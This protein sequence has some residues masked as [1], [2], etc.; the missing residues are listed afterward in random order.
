MENEKK[1]KDMYKTKQYQV[2]TSKKSRK[3]DENNKTKKGKKKKK[4]KVLKRIILTFFIL[5]FLLIIAAVG[6]V[7]G[8][9][10]SDKWAITTAELIAN[11]NTEV[12][13]SENNLLAVLS[14]RGGDG[15]RKVVALDEMGKY[16]ANAYIAIEDKRFYEHSGVDLIRTAKATASYILHRGSSDVGGGSTLTQQLVKN[17]MKDDDNTG[18]AGMERKIREMSRAYQIEGMLT[19]QQ[20]IEK[21]L[22]VI[23][24]GGNDLHGVEY[25]AQYYF[26]KSAKDLDLAESAFLAGINNAPNMYDPYDTK[27]DHSELIKNRTKLVL[28]FMKEQ[29]RISDNPEEAEKLYN[30]AVAKVEKGL[31]FKKGKIELENISYFVAEAVKDVARDLA[32]ERDISLDEAQSMIRSGGYK[33]YTTQVPSIQNKVISEMAKE[34]YIEKRTITKKDENGKTVKETLR[35]NAGMTIIEHSTGKVVAMGGDLLQDVGGN[36]NHAMLINRQNGSSMKPLA[37]IAVGLEEKVITAATIYDDTRTKFKEMPTAPKNVGSYMG[38]I[39]TRKAIEVSSNIVNLKIMSNIGINK[40]VEYLNEF[41]LTT[42]KKGEEGLTLAIGGVEHGSST[43]QMAAA[44]AT[45]ANKGVYIE[46]TFYTKL[47]DSDGKIV[48]EPKQETRRVISEA[49]AFIVS[50]ILMDVVTGAQGT[51]GSCAIS[52]MDVAAKTGTTDNSTDRTLCGYTPYYA[53]ATWYGYGDSTVPIRKDT[54]KNIW[55]KVMK[56]VHKNLP[57]KRFEKPDS[58]VTAKVCRASGKLAT[59]SCKSTYSE[60]FAVGNVPK[61]CDGH[62]AVRI[63]KETGKVANEYCPEVEEKIYASTPEKE[64]NAS[65][66]PVSGKSSSVAPTEKCTKHTEETNKIVVENVVGKKESEAKTALAGLNIQVIYETHSDKPN[67]EVLRQ[68]LSEG[69]KVDKG[70]TIVITVNKYENSSSGGNTQNPNT[71][72]E[73]GN[74]NETGNGENTNTNTGTGNNTGTNNNESVN[75]PPVI[76]EPPVSTTQTTKPQTTKPQITKPT[77]PVTPP[78]TPTT[79]EV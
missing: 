4:H 18:V 66:K 29:N 40:S 74:G 69:T 20:I 45:L 28:N 78:T 77:T 58:V 34:T 46:P 63:C 32:E 5:M 38:L 23:F 36:I 21:Y 8:I 65:W 62:S 16:T 76:N 68:S 70:V 48:L 52:G 39:T 14:V 22:N 53:A 56:D 47:V 75:K 19:K 57:K 79:N 25:G 43:L 33:L 27:N 26:A 6:I 30:E 54:A 41:G 59:S 42:Y 73:N 35:T 67:G 24:V 10:F 49:N 12:Y 31:P 7:A 3:H 71:N 51:A 17:L 60:F 11:G 50:D 64:Q 72:T 44:Y 2:Q 15:N 9:F 1:D 13:D 37:N 61:E 55:A